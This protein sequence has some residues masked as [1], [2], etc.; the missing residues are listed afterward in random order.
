[1]RTLHAV[2]DRPGWWKPNPTRTADGT[3]PGM[4]GF[5]NLAKPLAKERQACTPSGARA[6]RHGRHEG[7]SGA[8][9]SYNSRSTLSR[10]A[11]RR[12]DVRQA[13]LA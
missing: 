7:V 11:A 8:R 3:S 9:V 12:F 10:T 5:D 6:D 4:Y 1:M 2:G 13:A